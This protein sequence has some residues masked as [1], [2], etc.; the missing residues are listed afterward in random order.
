MKKENA[1]VIRQCDELGRLIIPYVLREELE[2]K[3]K[4]P[5]EMKIEG[6]KLIIKKA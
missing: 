6:D 3:T 5:L 4:E 2:I 1:R